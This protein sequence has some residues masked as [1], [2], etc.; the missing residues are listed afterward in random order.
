MGVYDTGQLI[1]QQ[2][3]LNQEMHPSNASDW[4]ITPQMDALPAPLQHIDTCMYSAN[5]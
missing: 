1:L 4:R 5:E 3:G 2:P